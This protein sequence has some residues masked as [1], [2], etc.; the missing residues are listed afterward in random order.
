MLFASLL[1]NYVSYAESEKGLNFQAR[2]EVSH[3]SIQ[4]APMAKAKS[5]FFCRFRH[6]LT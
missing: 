2:S 4:N 5:S 1:E 3:G 6:D